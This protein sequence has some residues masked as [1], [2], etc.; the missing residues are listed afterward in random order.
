MQGNFSVFDNF[1]FSSPLSHT[2]LKGPDKKSIIGFRQ[3]YYSIS[4]WSNK[5]NAYH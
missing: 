1:V 4:V 5:Y 3:K 2:N